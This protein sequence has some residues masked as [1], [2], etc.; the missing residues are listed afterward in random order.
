[1][2]IGWSAVIGILQANSVHEPHKD[3]QTHPLYVHKAVFRTLLPP[4]ATLEL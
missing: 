4:T 3:A 2:S 1:M